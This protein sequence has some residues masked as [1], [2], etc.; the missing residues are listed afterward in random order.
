[1]YANIFTKSVRDRW[2]GEVVGA[3]SIGL[4]LLMSM[5]IYADID[6]SFYYE[7]PEGILD[8]V[9]ISEA[10]GGAAGIAY[11]AIYNLMGAM[12]LAGLAISMGSRSIAGEEREGTIGL[13]LGNPRSRTSVLLSKLG[14]LVV[15]TAVGG[16]LMW[17]AGVAAPVLLGADVGSVDVLALMLHMAAN[18]LFWGMLAAAIGAWTGSRTAASAVAAGVMVLSY[19]AA[20]LLPL[21]EGM[22]DAAEFFPWYWFSGSSPEINGIHAGHLALLVGGSVALG[23]VALVGLQRRDLRTRSTGTS[24]FDRLRAN[25]RTKALADRIGGSARVSSLVAKASADHQGLLVSVAAVIG[26]MGM[27]FGPMYALLPEGFTDMVEQ[28]PDTLLAMVGQADMATPAGWYT[29]EMFALT[30]P[31][32]FIAVLAIVGAKGLAGEEEDHTMGL[33]LAN[34]IP[35]RRVLLAKATV[36]TVYAV[37]LGVAAFVG[38]AIGVV[39]ANLDI[40]LVNLA[41][42]SLLAALLSLVH[43]AV[44][45]AIG[46]ATGKPRLA[47]IGATA[48]ALVG[49]F[50]DSFLPLSEGLADWAALSPFNYY[51]ASNPLENGIPW[52]DAGVLAALVVVLFAVAVPLFERRDLRG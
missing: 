17:A 33:L 15:L 29:G 49:Y 38:S 47:I 36:L 30:A 4:L 3:V 13:L 32:A 39:L 27:Y 43:G 34:P 28:F 51:I 19:L 24:L 40:S 50:V 41:G 6:I 2:I 11:G 7:L 12:T 8:L 52:A 45:L 44:A 20:S 5:A 18:A 35:R 25:P 9:G 48:V 10:T 37:V 22:A 46:A 14:A 23:A 16:A 26:F 1:M 42:T 31:L 21:F